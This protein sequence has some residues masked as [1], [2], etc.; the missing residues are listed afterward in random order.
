M[1]AVAAGNYVENLLLTRDHDG[2]HLAGRCRELVVLDASEG[3]EDESGIRAE[4]GVLGDTE[5]W[6]SGIK[7]TGAPYLGIWLDSGLLEATRIALVGNLVFGASAFG[8]S[9]EMVLSDTEI[10]DTQP[11]PNGT[12]GRGLNVQ[13]GARLEAYSCLVSGNTEI[14]IFAAGDAEV[15]LRNVEV[16]DTHFQ[17]VGAGGCGIGVQ[18]GAR[19]EAYSCLVSGNA[20]VGI[21]ASHDA[22]VVLRDVEVRDTGQTHSTTV[23]TGVGSQEDAEL[24]ATDLLV[25]ETEGLGIFATTSGSLSCSG[26]D[27]LGNTFAGALAWGGGAIDLSN[28]T[29]SGTR[30]DANEGGGIGI[31]ASDRRAD[32]HGPPSLTLDAVTI[33][34]QPYAALWLDGDGSYSISGST[35]VGGYGMEIEYPDGTVALKY[36]DGVV[37][38]GGISIWDG[39]GG[40]LLESTEIRD[41][42][43][44]GVL[45]DAS[46]ATLSHNTFT[47]NGT[48][49]IWRN[50]ADTPAPIGID[51]IPIVDD[52]PVFNHH[53]P[54]LEF[55]LYLEE[56]APLDWEDAARSAAPPAPLPSLPTGP[57]IPLLEPLSMAPSPT[58]RPMITVPIHRHE[59]LPTSEPLPV[60]PR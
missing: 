55:N 46:S 41:A 57:S 50:H 7:V 9:S 44:S 47:N 29:I 49:L 33:E 5:W 23:A 38:L 3:E 56:I 16:R 52:C 10:L 28:T 18:E 42:T 37:A 60:I 17:Q 19:L 25:S 15:V 58:I 54:E 34:D 1:V 35:L 45:L 31:Y 40:L 6:V 12:Y 11:L 27:L 26:C 43:R 30:P 20:D 32:S 22:E 39:S 53:I 24:L 14:G 51:D 48:D 4:A 59:P 2:V 36:G 21:L 13:E 8:A